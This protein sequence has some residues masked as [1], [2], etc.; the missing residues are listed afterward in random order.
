VKRS[1][2]F[3]A[4]H[5]SQQQ[6]SPRIHVTEPPIE[7]YFDIQSEGS[8]SERRFSHEDFGIEGTEN[9]EIEA[10]DN[11]GTISPSQR[12]LLLVLQHHGETFDRG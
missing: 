11:L 6:P 12:N 4:Q 1:R 2:S 5:P 3:L 7:G 8:A 10:S 9:D